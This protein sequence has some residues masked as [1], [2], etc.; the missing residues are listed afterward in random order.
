VA[1]SGFYFFLNQ[2]Y[3]SINLNICVGVEVHMR[4]LS[5]PALHHLEDESSGGMKHVDMLDQIMFI[6]VFRKSPQT[7]Y[8][9]T[10]QIYNHSRQ[11]CQLNPRASFT[12]PRTPAEAPAPPPPPPSW[13]PPGGAALQRSVRE[14]SYLVPILHLS[15]RQETAGC[16]FLR[17]SK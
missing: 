12:T 13:S 4:N 14:P 5:I 8:R 17:F 9:G 1:E 3:L 11:K 15:A 7:V 2:N 6:N 10:L 16:L